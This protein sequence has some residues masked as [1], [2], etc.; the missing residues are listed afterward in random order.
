MGPKLPKQHFKAQKSKIELKMSKNDFGLDASDWERV[1]LRM[2]PAS[3]QNFGR[4]QTGRHSAFCLS[5]EPLG[6]SWGPTQDRPENGPFSNVLCQWF[7]SRTAAIDLRAFASPTRWKRGAAPDRKFDSI[8]S[9]FFLRKPAGLGACSVL[10]S[11]RVCDPTCIA[12]PGQLLR[13]GSIWKASGPPMPGCWALGHLF[14][15]CRPSCLLACLAMAFNTCRARRKETSGPAPAPRAGSVGRPRPQVRPHFFLDFSCEGRLGSQCSVL[16]SSRACGPYLHRTSLP[17]LPR[18]GSTWRASGPP[19]PGCWAL[20]HLFRFC[21]LSC[22]LACPAMAFNTCRARRKETS[23]PAPAPRAGSVGRPRPQ[24]RPNFFLDFSCEG[25]LGSQLAPCSALHAL[26]AL[27]ASHVPAP[28]A[29]DR[30]HMEG[31]GPTN[32]WL[33]GPG[34]FVSFLQAILLA[35]LSGNC[36][37][38]M[39]CLV[40]ETSGPLPAPRTAVR[41][42]PTANP[43]PISG[44][45]F[46]QMPVGVAASS[47]L[48]SSRACGSTCI[49]VSTGRL[50]F[51]VPLAVCPW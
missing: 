15:F 17:Q 12:R 3:L 11:S 25:R 45:F 7:N 41:R 46:L 44:L 13:S 21:R 2:A 37:Q 24:V 50:G 26:A 31:F 38:Y 23:G 30:Q 5:W 42:P 28:A 10:C 43:L 22:L 29:S 32:A 9:C 36:F 39:P 49:A 8:S 40:R 51:L 27:P 33:L 16:C 34:P 47:V 18:T 20:G 4:S 6:P 1:A 35:C 14:R 19:M 48:C